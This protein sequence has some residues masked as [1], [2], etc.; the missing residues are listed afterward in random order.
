MDELGELLAAAGNTRTVLKGL[1]RQ[2]RAA[3]Q[4]TTDLETRVARLEE[5]LR[6]LTAHKEAERHDTA[7]ENTRTNVAA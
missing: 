2:A 5:T 4:L 7:E 3:L 1:Q 6:D